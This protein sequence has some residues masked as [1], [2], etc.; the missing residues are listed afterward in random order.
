VKENQELDIATTARLVA[1]QARRDRSRAPTRTP[2]RSPR[3]AR[4]LLTISLIALLVA[5]M[6]N[7]LGWNPLA[8]QIPKQTPE[9]EAESR[10]EV[11]ALKVDWVE[12]YREENGHLPEAPP[13]PEGPWEVSNVDEVH[14]EV[15]LV[16]GKE[17]IVYASRDAYAEPLA[18]NYRGASR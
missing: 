6:L 5:T 1:N 14:F 10:A 17:Q 8:V 2:D 15:V 7:L 3:R 16:D 18:A 9:Q 4:S 11:L 13:G 12:G